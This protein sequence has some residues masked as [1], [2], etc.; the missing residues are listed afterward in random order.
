MTKRPKHKKR[1]QF[2]KLPPKHIFFLNPYT[3]ERFTRCPKCGGK[4]LKRKRPFLIHID[5]QLLMN[6]NL[7]TPYCPVCDLIIMHQ[8]VLEQFLAESCERNGRP[9]LI[10]NNYLVIGTVERSA[11]ARSFEDTHLTFE[12]TVAHSHD[13]KEVV[14]FEIRYE[15]PDQNA[16]EKDK[17]PDDDPPQKTD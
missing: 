12:D 15:I 4:T 17:G 1:V 2:G 14:R 5:P 10:G 7:T 3:N 8:D 13:F 6:C 9:D 16:L 11:F